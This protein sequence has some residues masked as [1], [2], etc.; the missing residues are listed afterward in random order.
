[1]QICKTVILR[2][3]KIKGGMLSF[4]LDYYPGYRD[5]FTMKVVRH[6]SL[7]IYIY[8][9]PKNQQQIDYNETMTAKAEV[10]RCRRFETIVNER[11]D[12][13]DSGRF[14]GDFLEYFRMVLKKKDK[15]WEFVYAHFSNFVNGKCTFGEVDVD[16]CRRFREYLLTAKNMR[17]GKQMAVNSVAGYYSTFRGFLNIAY[18]DRKIRENVNDYLDKID[19]VGT[20]KSSLN[21]DE[22]RILYHSQC[23]YDVLKQASIFSCLTGLRRSDILNLDWEN[24]K[25]Y[26][27][28]GRYI[29]F[30][31]QKTKQRNIIPLN[32]VAL[33]QMGEEQKTG[34]V[35]KGFKIIMT[36]YILKNWLKDIGIEKHVTFHSF[37]HTF[38]SLQL[39]LGTDIY[40][41]QNL[42]AHKSVTTTQIYARHADPKR[43]EAANRI[44]M[45]MLNYVPEDAEEGNT[46]EPK[47]ENNSILTEKTDKKEKQ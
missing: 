11:Y 24:V 28:G 13:L 19:Y 38:A 36:Q 21:L 15:K 5:S 47:Q 34:Q 2:T 16:L 43:R 14:K 4:Y 25:T 41:V 23:K 35:F 37:R 31:S 29:E 39:E 30:I 33:Q 20:E 40:T 12:I 7:G 26:A 17:T 6:E 44:S 10:I 9:E 42:L 32:D 46:D 8:E 1:M 3:R 45:D 22:L 27:D 18:R